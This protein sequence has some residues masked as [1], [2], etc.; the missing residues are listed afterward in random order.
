VRAYGELS[1]VS[2]L[3][4]AAQEH[5]GVGWWQSLCRTAACRRRGARPRA[6]TAGANRRGH[7]S[8]C[9]GAVLSYGQNK[10]L[11]IAERP[12]RELCVRVA[13]TIASWTSALKMSILIKG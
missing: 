7:L 10:L 12:G 6:Q 11:A 3:C 4:L 2:N 8:R 1:L 9:A 13:S 5:D